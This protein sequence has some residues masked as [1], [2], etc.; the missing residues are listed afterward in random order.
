[1][2]ICICC[3][4]RLVRHLNCQRIYW[5]CRSCYQE[6]PNIYE[7]YACTISELSQQLATS[8]IEKDII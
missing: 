1:M 7:S 8:S 4:D 6:M 2:S 3:G 5:F